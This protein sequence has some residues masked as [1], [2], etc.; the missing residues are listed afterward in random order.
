MVLAELARAEANL[1]RFNSPHEAYAVLLEKMDDLWQEIKHGTH[2]RATADATQV[3][4]TAL[5]WLIDLAE[6]EP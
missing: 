4:A 1:E 6:V 3:G 2:E 5:R